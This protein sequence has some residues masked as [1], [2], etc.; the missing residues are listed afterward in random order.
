MLGSH[1]TFDQTICE[2]LDHQDNT[3]IGSSY[4]GVSVRS[5]RQIRSRSSIFR[6]VWSLETQDQQ[7]RSRSRSDRIFSQPLESRDGGDTK[8]EAAR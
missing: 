4:I 8:A 2:N 7:I 3:Y 5:D 6:L 1:F